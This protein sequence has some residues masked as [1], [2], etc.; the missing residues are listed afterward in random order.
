[1]KSFSKR[2]G[3]GQADAPITIRHDAPDW[4]RSLIVRYAYEANLRPSS[5]RGVL[6]DLLLEAPD[7]S[8]WSEFPNIDSEVQELLS[9]ADWY[10][11]Y[12]LIE[13][14]VDTL[15]K[16]SN[17][18]KTEE[19]CAKINEAFRRKGV[20][21][22]LVNG[23]IQIRG[24]ESFEKSL[25][26]AVA[27]A[28]ETKRPVSQ[29]E[30]HSALQ[31]LSK[32]PHPDITGAIR[33]GMAALECVARDIT[34]DVNATLGEIIKRNPGLVPSPLDKSLE[35]IWGYASDKARHIREGDIIEIEEAELLV[36]LAGSIATYLIKKMKNP[37]IS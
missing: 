25:S 4:L 18:D 9:K 13:I 23:R 14:I 3:L 8:N 2:H 19:F 28:A 16:S 29:N 24:E 21:W 10:Q 26:E 31:D 34:G 27:A 37:A 6:C 32:R 22:Q 35:K 11:V 7:S 5:L 17:Y 33:H 20:A 1:M 12:D 15:S 36:G 30:F